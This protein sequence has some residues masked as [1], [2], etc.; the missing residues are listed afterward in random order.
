MTVVCWLLWIASVC[1]AAFLYGVKPTDPLTYRIVVI[2]LVSIALLARFIRPPRRKSRPNGSPAPGMKLGTAKLKL[3]TF[4]KVEIQENKKP[5]P[6]IGT[7]S[8]R[9]KLLRP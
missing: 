9:F 3:E 1:F 2:V 5:A 4:V 7:G 6:V 8:M